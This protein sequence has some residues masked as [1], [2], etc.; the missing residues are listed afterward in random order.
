MLG[1]YGTLNHHRS[2]KHGTRQFWSNEP[3]V[4]STVGEFGRSCL[5]GRLCT[6]GICRQQRLGRPGGSGRELGNRGP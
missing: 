4:Q 2:R 1:R 6:A 5:G 3:L